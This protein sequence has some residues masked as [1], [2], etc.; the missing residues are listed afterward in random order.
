MNSEGVKMQDMEARI[1][2]FEALRQLDQDFTLY[3]PS[4][5]EDKPVVYTY[6]PVYLTFEQYEEL[7]KGA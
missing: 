5:V 3:G 1:T 4:I 2:A 6:E 7:G